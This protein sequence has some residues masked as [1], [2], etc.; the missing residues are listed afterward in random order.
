MENQ[1]YIVKIFGGSFLITITA[2]VVLYGYVSI[3]KLYAGFI[4]ILVIIFGL[5]SVYDG[6]KNE[7]FNNKKAEASEI[8]IIFKTINVFFSDILIKKRPPFFF[9]AII[10]LGMSRV[11]FSIDSASYLYGGIFNNW[12][13]TFVVSILLSFFLGYVAYYFGGIV[14]DLGIM[15]S[16]GK[17]N[18]AFSRNLF[19][20]SWFPMALVII[21]GKI[22][23]AVLYGNEYFILSVPQNVK[24]ITIL[25]VILT[26]LIGA[27][28]SYK[29]VR[30]HQKLKFLQAFFL[31]VVLPIGFLIKLSTP[32]ISDAFDKS[33][34]AYD[35]EAQAKIFLNEGAYGKSIDAYEKAIESLNQQSQKDKIVT[36][37]INLAKI[38]QIQGNVDGMKKEFNNAL[39]YL[40]DKDAMHHSIIGRLSLLEPNVKKAIVSFEKALEIDELD[41]IANNMLSILYLDI[42]DPEINSPNKAIVYSKKAYSVDPDDLGVNQNLA[43]NYFLLEQF[44]DALPIFNRLVI[45][46][47]DNYLIQYYLGMTYYEL[48]NMSDAKVHLQNAISLNKNLL[49]DELKE[50]LNSM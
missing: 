31:F 41:F 49:T 25:S 15:L 3:A 32:M 19:L 47:P 36:T 2:F 10:I 21:I 27:Y 40:S 13:Y 1:K 50:M 6:I 20:Y 5:Y 35:Y 22:I 34:S 26:G 46:S 43:L 17:R 23:Q 14:Y 28:I 42:N 37:H 11:L 7:Y 24:L 29:G 38:M 33:S 4:V 9:T 8:L 16:K 45:N 44:T 18:M 30:K 12:I 39:S 48:G